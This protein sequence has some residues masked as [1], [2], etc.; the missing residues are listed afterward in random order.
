[1]RMPLAGIRADSFDQKGA[2]RRR[3]N[4]ANE[5]SFAASDAA[6]PVILEGARFVSCAS[7]RRAVFWQ[8]VLPFV[9]TAE[10]RFRRSRR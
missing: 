10:A 6:L 1:M 2:R 5:H 9:E 7:P 8:D 4:S 3:A